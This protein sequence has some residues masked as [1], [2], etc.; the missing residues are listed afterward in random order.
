MTK[1]TLLAATFLCLALTAAQS[2]SRL[3]NDTKGI[4]YN[5]EKAIDIRVH[6][7]GW[8]ANFMVGKI[9]SYYKTTFY[10]FGLGELRH[11]KEVSESTDYS[12][13]SPGSG[14][15]Q[16]IFGKQNY[17]FVLRGGYGVKRY[18]TEKASKKGVALAI[19]YSGGATLALMMPYYLEVNNGS[20]EPS[21]SKEIKYSSE[22]ASVFLDKYKIRG[23]A[24]VFKGIGETSFVPGIHGQIGVHLDWGAFDE[25]LRA[26]EVGVQLDVFPKK[27]PLMVD[28]P[29][30]EN[31]PFFFNLYVSLQLG[32]RN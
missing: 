2:Q 21:G 17:G 12:A 32:K 22:T 20:R 14:F 5:D 11:F 10:R 15:R 19:S 6:T 1:Q 28:I 13:F 25:F 9:K 27:L 31:R 8:A 24:S 23:A 29:T 18:Y 3:N 30:N 16:Y 26:L 7:H 4:I